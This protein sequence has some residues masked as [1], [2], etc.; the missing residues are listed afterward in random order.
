MDIGF[1][2][3]GSR[4]IWFGVRLCLVCSCSSVTEISPGNVQPTNSFVFLG[5]ITLKIHKNYNFNL[6]NTRSL[7]FGLC[8]KCI[9]MEK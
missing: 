6:K 2:Q 3:I 7:G 4:F 9:S 8:V 5:H 1:E